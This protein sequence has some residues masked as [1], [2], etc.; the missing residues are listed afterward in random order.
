VRKGSEVTPLAEWQT[1]LA[2]QAGAAATLTGLVFV[3]V[4][5]NLARILETTGLSG[6]AA[7]SILH[8][9]QVFFICTATLI[10]RQPMMA[11]GIEILMIS[12]FSWAMQL[13]TQ[14]RY[15]RSRSGH[16]LFWLSIRILQTQL[17]S[18]PFVVGAIFL[19]LGWPAGLYWLV[20]GFAFS[21]VAG[22]ANAWVLLI[23]I[24]R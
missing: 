18:I 11:L 14:I 10:P 22:V 24:L 15:A 21:F 4:S 12:L 19:L 13:G 9:L 17:A 7:E 2:V 8:F 20:P 6:R 1:L 23:E 5:I 3:A 16:P